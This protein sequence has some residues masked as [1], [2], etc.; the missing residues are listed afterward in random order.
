MARAFVTKIPIAGFARVEVRADAGGLKSIYVGDAMQVQLPTVLPC[1][2]LREY[3]RQA[4]RFGVATRGEEVRSGEYSDEDA[5]ENADM[6]FFAAGAI[7]LLQKGCVEDGQAQSGWAILACSC[8]LAALPYWR[9]WMTPAA[10]S[11]VELFCV[12]TVCAFAVDQQRRMRARRNSFD[13]DYQW[14]MQQC[15]SE[16][17]RRAG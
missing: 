3:V 8:L 9:R 11:D 4:A 14:Q 12:L 13:D 7:H 17:A 5:M 16:M 15:V 6:Y 10:L 2:I 1:G